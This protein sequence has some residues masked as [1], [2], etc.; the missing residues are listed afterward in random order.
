MKEENLGLKE[1]YVRLKLKNGVTRFPNKV[2]ND[3]ASARMFAYDL[4]KDLDR[5]WVIVINLDTKL[6]PINYSVVSVGDLNRALISC[7][8]TFKS[9][10]LSNANSIMVFH[11]HPSGDV[12]PS[13]DDMQTTRRL[14]EV[15]KL[16]GIPLL[17]H[18]IVG[19]VTYNYYSFFESHEDWFK[20]S[21]IDLELINS[22]AKTSSVAESAET[23]N[24][25]ES[26]G[27]EIEYFSN[28][29]SN[30]MNYLRQASY[31]VDY[32]PAE[33]LR[34]V[35]HFP[36]CKAIATK[37]VWDQIG[38]RIK[39]NEKPF[40]DESNN[41]KEYYELSQISD[42]QRSLFEKRFLWNRDGLHGDGWK[43]INRGL[44]QEH[45]E[46]NI[47]ESMSEFEVVKI[48]VRDLYMS[49]FS[50]LG[51]QDLSPGDLSAVQN[52]IIDSVSWSITTRLS[53]DSSVFYPV[54]DRDIIYLR[55]K[56][57]FSQSFL[58][59][60]KLEGLMSDFLKSSIKSIRNEVKNEGK[61]KTAT[62]HTHE[63]GGRSGVEGVRTTKSDLV[64]GKSSGE[65]AGNAQRL[66]RDNG[67]FSAVPEERTGYGTGL[68]QEGARSPKGR[69][70]GSADAERAMGYV[71]A[72]T[73]DRGE[74]VRGTRNGLSVNNN[75]SDSDTENLSNE[76]SD[77]YI[78]T[79]NAEAGRLL[80][81][82]SHK[83]FESYFSKEWDFDDLS[84]LYPDHKELIDGIHRLAI[85]ICTINEQPT[86]QIRFSKYKSHDLIDVK[87]R[88]LSLTKDHIKYVLDSIINANRKIFNP[89]AYLLT[90]LYNS[91][92]S[93]SL[94]Q[95]SKERSE[96]VENPHGFQEH[97]YTKEQLAE[98]EEHLMSFPEPFGDY[99][100]AAKIPDDQIVLKVKDE[101]A[102][103][104][105]WYAVRSG[106]VNVSANEV[107]PLALIYDTGKIIWGDNVSDEDKRTIEEK[108]SDFRSNFLKKYNSLSAEEKF[109][110]IIM[111]APAKIR[112]FMY[113]E[114]EVHGIP[115]EEVCE[116]YFS[117]AVL[118]E[119]HEP[120]PHVNISKSDIKQIEDLVKKVSDSTSSDRP[121]LSS[122][123][124]H[125][126]YTLF[127]Y[128]FRDALNNEP[129]AY[130]EYHHVNGHKDIYL[131][132][133]LG[134][135][136]T[137]SLAYGKKADNSNLINFETEIRFIPDRILE[138]VDIL[139]L[140]ESGKLIYSKDESI[141]NQKEKSDV[142][143]FFLQW[144]KSIDAVGYV[145]TPNI[146][147][148]W[149]I[150]D[151]NVSESDTEKEAVNPV[152]DSD[153]KV[154]TENSVSDS[155]T[156]TESAWSN[157]NPAAVKQHLE[158]NGVLNG[159]VIDEQKLNKDSFVAMVSNSID[160]NS[161]GVTQTPAAINHNF[162]F[163]NDDVAT[164]TP[165]VRFN[166]NIAALRTLARI[167]E[168]T[169]VT[170][171]DK[172]I[173]SEYSGWGGLS[174][175]FDENN[176]S[177]HNE[178][179]ALKEM[180]S[181][182]E[183]QSARSS[184]LNAHYTGA[185]IIRGVYQLLSEMGFSGGNILEPSMGTGHFFGLMPESIA[186]RSTLTGV[187]LDSISG[188]ISQ[189]LYPSADITIG[190]F[191]ET[192][193]SNYYDLAVGNVP[194]GQYGVNDPKFNSLNLNI[195]NYFFVKAL[196]EVR[197]GGLVCFLTSRYTMDSKNSKV[198]KYLAERADLVTAIRFPED[199][200]HDT[201]NT[202]VIS[203]L[204]VFKK[205]DRPMVLNSFPDW[206]DLGL[207][208][209]E[210][211]IN[212]YFL[213]NPDHVFGTLSV[214]SGAF[215]KELSVEPYK[216][217]K[218]SELFSGLTVP[219]IYKE[220]QT[221]PAISSDEIH[222]GTIA[223]DPSIKN[224]EYGLIDG[225]LYYREDNIMYPP[226]DIGEKKEARIIGMIQI[227]DKMHKVI[228]LQVD[229]ADDDTLKKAQMSLNDTYDS[230]VKKYGHVND[231]ANANVFAVCSDYFLI[232]GLEILD[233]DQN[234]VSKSDI[235]SKRTINP[236]IT[237][238]S[239]KT[240]H[241]ALIN[242]L[243]M[244]GHVD[245]DYMNMLLGWGEGG[246]EKITDE[247]GDS[248][249]KDPLTAGK[250]DY[251]G[252]GWL[253]A[254][255]YL[256]GN[257]RNKLEPAKSA[258]A[259][260]PRFN[261]NVNALIAV[262]PKPLDA[263]EI[264][265]RL[266]ATWIDTSYYTDFLV[267]IFDLKGWQRDLHDV[268]FEPVTGT[269]RVCKK[270][271]FYN[272][273]VAVFSTYGTHA[274]NAAYILEDCLNLKS[275]KVYSYDGKERHINEK[276]TRIAQMKQE[277]LKRAFS[278]WIFKD[279]DRRKALVDKYNSIFNCIRERKYDGSYLA[280]HLPGINNAIQ[281]RQ[282]QLDAVSRILTNGNT[283]LAHSV[284]AGKT[285]AMIASAM[286]SK[287]LGLCHKPMFVVP[288]SL[289]KQWG[290]DFLLLYPSANILV[291][292]NKSFEKKNRK[293]FTSRIATGDYDA[294]IVSN[295]QF[296]AIPM[297]RDLQKSFFTDQIESAV[298]AK[299]EI[300]FSS[301]YQQK[302]FSINQLERFIKKLNTRLSK[303]LEKN[304]K[305]DV[306]S[307]DKLG[308]DRL[309]V[310][311]AHRYKNLFFFSNL[312]SVPGVNAGSDTE[313][314]LDMEMKVTYI[315]D[316]TD[317]KGVVFAT[318]TPVSNS[319]SE[320]YVMMKYLCPQLMKDL[321]FT[322]FDAWATTF[323]E[324][325]NA[326]ELSPEGNG[327]TVKQRF[328]KFY[329]VPELMK[330]FHSV[331]DVKL[332]DD[333]HLNVPA[334]TRHEVIV[335]PTHKQLEMMKELSGRAKR[336]H[337]HAVDPSEDNM[338]K[339]TTDG[340]KIGLDPRI[341][342]PDAFDDPESKINVAVNNI[343]E[344][345]S[346]TQ[347]D[348]LTQLVFCDFSTP[349]SDGFNVYDDMREKLISRG[350]PE[351]E[352]A[353]IHDA[354]TDQ[355]KEALFDKVRAGTVRIMFGSTQK[356]GEGVNVQN[357]LIAIHH[358]DAPWKPSDM[359]QR[360]GRIIRQGNENSNVHIYTYATDRTFDSYL[361]QT[362][363]RKQ[364]FI[365][366]IM[367][368][369]STSREME[370]MDDRAMNYAEIMSATAGSP[371]LKEKL[372]LDMDLADMRMLRTAF[373]KN[374]MD[375]QDKIR[376][377]I[378]DR[379]KNTEKTIE[380][381]KSDMKTADAN[382]LPVLADSDEDDLKSFAG[383]TIRGNNYKLLSDVSKALSFWRESHFPVMFEEIGEYRGFKIFARDDGFEDYE[384]KLEGAGD[385]TTN[386]GKSASAFFA[387][388]DK[389]IEEFPSEL[390]AAYD[391]LDNLKI[392]LEKS[393][394]D[395]EKPYP[396]EEKYQEMERRLAELNAK[397]SL[398]DNTED[399]L[400]DNDEKTVIIS[401]PEA[402][403][404]HSVQESQCV[405]EDTLEPR[406]TD[407][408][409]V[410][411]TDDEQEEFIKRSR[412]I[413]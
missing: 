174:A 371:E 1:V 130:S 369:K 128:L 124:N 211:P 379:I 17:D 341:I 257:V 54:T 154:E 199:A 112:S 321:G 316:K 147:R 177:W 355:K 151:D 109:G 386:L 323:G 306:I 392:S 7:S 23:Y 195:H 216:D 175:A 126:C 335:P 289:L 204:L 372:Q 60:F 39:D 99:E 396:D 404:F 47:D 162:K 339:I 308:I 86:Y 327:F 206:V 284:G 356:M 346:D 292:D 249:F 251:Y 291:A 242:S 6:H 29:R 208:A 163:S 125:D 118:N 399:G 94:Y 26:F 35:R 268:L 153:T 320:C 43:D 290:R 102:A 129:W 58:A 219:F 164:G 68:Y 133:V 315:N 141:E 264:S 276:E 31:L 87:K 352:I 298:E 313:R 228:D 380:N 148:G 158:E 287:R 194:F 363:L 239:A 201:A 393:K 95:K 72:V 378:P 261:K 149:T 365:G 157:L 210:I 325:T 105:S 12:E 132:H 391:R 196:D 57:I 259:I 374:K 19:G 281:L 83:D 10:I 155:D 231:R 81:S 111:R 283:L 172:K 5:E 14:I 214:K 224:Y 183:Y 173:L 314:S 88:F 122:S 135:D 260:D 348:R 156:K 44:L 373:N 263:S 159:E 123:V 66:Q 253:T 337:T 349:K 244:K 220:K 24:A 192:N 234:F 62:Y 103:F 288:K 272:E 30:F 345:W 41:R 269:W 21:K 202:E 217:R 390:S 152:S 397:L 3:P 274:R 2:I 37:E 305:D 169:S 67:V 403:K 304:P 78:D 375:L 20:D 198:R 293:K 232:C 90:S 33:S 150:I 238:V 121:V 336:V 161:V 318:G 245:L 302:R 113:A 296:S 115:K 91:Y 406:F 106:D 50:E 286:E 400:I 182:D 166:K 107:N 168:T 188:R 97:H 254:D 389:I 309:Y 360:E 145:N 347:A 344:I 70:A 297:S 84:S 104:T 191:E 266:G 377:V 85:E 222:P 398:N 160:N 256:S 51:L 227:A 178:Y 265:V 137:F 230:F 38:A 42:N 55:D 98:L 395:S 385:Y 46:L 247:L 262:Q 25:D 324:I 110:L 36:Q 358:I 303:T 410:E 328:A 185:Q 76:S 368:N 322:N 229:G 334:Y 100:N 15:G 79:D 394:E 28:S 117:Y 82:V 353:F 299:N 16:L 140:K 351:D 213:D 71:D 300:A 280:N 165:K 285:F 116:R 189:I 248:I 252:D 181:D 52:F 69:N 73:G 215:G 384:V 142:E 45:T 255:E 4:M 301:D 343:F 56:H 401:S 77:E 167:T 411:N 236:K 197:P 275:S 311:E 366:Q 340:R 63:L 143:E 235:F 170:D 136:T 250:G 267:E 180:L 226:V 96:N 64:K 237:V 312:S 131:D 193:K 53:D 359:E 120:D 34:F 9:A 49:H 413:L 11:N 65:S 225:K 89:R 409:S 92:D 32:T 370:D 408:S 80:H 405:A 246:K 307:F 209:D 412:P 270:D 240:P 277:E 233:S 187:E 354:N 144:L 200:F 317:Y 331:A 279:P 383:V 179:I 319:V 22:T 138:T 295:E 357:K 27:S 18:C 171:E 40:V 108:T 387:R 8:N 273:N 388:L 114:A 338:L 190:G 381:L 361:Y 93:F 223:A 119:G 402:V 350:I 205:K 376:F 364:K 407:K 326:M 282:H 146:S 59:F 382:P 127:E 203:D 241:E 139:S 310:D 333:L 294:I 207:T 186:E 278:D 134:S 212:T 258:A 271:E 329:N 75:V 342:E 13:D 221:V 176:S 218:I 101:N 367:T 184:V 243:F 48:K 332:A 330:L 362:L 61:R 74:D